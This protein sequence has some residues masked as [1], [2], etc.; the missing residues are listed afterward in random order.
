MIRTQVQL[1]PEQ[2]KNLKRLSA[3]T[4]QS[5]AELVRQGVDQM[6]AG[7]GAPS[8]EEQ[9]QRS[10]QALGRFKSRRID[11]GREHDRYLAEIFKS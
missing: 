1:T 2:V 7:K 3:A 11:I 9:R 8:R 5:I 6:F 10:L 4:G